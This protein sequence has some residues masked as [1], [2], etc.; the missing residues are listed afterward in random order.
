MNLRICLFTACCG[1]IGSL[2]ASADEPQT[3]RKPTFWVIPHTH[4]EG[5]VFKTREEYLE[6][7][8]PNILK[9]MRLLRE[10]P[11]YHFTLDQV[12]YVRP[13]LERY[14][15]EEADFRQ[16]IK[17]GRL[18]LAGALDVMPD[19]NMPG[20][21]T[22]VRQMQYGKGYYRQKLGVDV[23]SGWLIDTFGHHAQMPQL[24]AKGG[25]K[26]FWFVRGVPRQDFPAEFFWEGIDGTRIA[27]FYLPHSY[28]LTYGSP[29][30]APA[31]R[32]WAIKQFELLTPNVH[33]SDRVGLAGPDVAEPEDHLVARIE[34]FNRDPQAPFTM[35]M[36]VPADFEKAVTGRGDRPVWK[37]ELNPIFQGTYSS[38]IEL[39]EWMR[40]M[41]Q[42]LLT[43]EKLSAL[44]AWL[45]APADLDGIW[46]GWEPVLFNQTHDLASGV[47]T[48]HVY[49]DTIRSYEFARRR[50]EAIIDGRWDV[51]ASKIDT[52]GPGAPVVVFNTLGWTRSDIAF[53]DAGFGAGG[54]S[55]IVLTDSDAKAVPAQIVASTRYADGGLKTARL[56]FIARDVPALGYATYHIVPESSA[57]GATRDRAIATVVSS[58]DSL[59][60]LEN[61]LYRLALDP[62]NGA[63]TSLRLRNNDW[64][65]F[66]ATGNVVAREQDR[67]DLW[68]LNKGL[69][70]GS[71]VAMTKRQ[72][73]PGRGQAV[74]SDEGKGEPGT[75]L[76]GR[77][78]SELT[79]ARP[80]GS[81]RFATT[82][83]I[84]AG[85][86][87]IEITT[88]LVNQ[89]KY[90]RYQALF[91]TTI[92]QGKST[93][94][95]PFGS[96]YRPAGIEFPAQ[97][98]IDH[99]DGQRGL[100]VLNIGLPGNVVTD[101][102]MM[103]S[104]MRAHTLGAYGFGGGYEPGMSSESGLQLG[105]E[106]TMRYA[107]IAHAGDWRDAG[108][109]RA[110]WE[111]NHPLLCRNV[112]TH[113]GALPRRWGLFDIGNPNVVVSSLK[114]TAG[115]DVALRIYESS[116]RPA[117]AVAIKLRAKV[118][119]AHKSNL[120]EDPD[121]PLAADGDTVRLDLGPFEIKTIRLRL[122]DS[123][124]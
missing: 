63:I 117:P 115:G 36:A 4:W 33:G 8:L 61:E 32:A 94:E 43:A 21:E 85:L 73:V 82:V 25:F 35:R 90:V 88:R 74:F 71:R 78:F 49:G 34:E 23:T 13:F 1:L 55:G 68:E 60:T 37:G 9:A 41:E 15:A 92:K 52:Q 91:P 12:A 17:E 122:G 108:I 28:A 121:T 102:T 58:A 79:V 51:I 80:F 53:V 119:S 106:R 103:V 105:T 30:D 42:R 39:K 26:T 86:R 101:G 109:V 40:V 107:L 11:D 95:I 99:G 66:A 31:F 50:A 87:R 62:R 118:E 65:V 84:Y 104:L 89:E 83:R 38:R 3:A 70:G 48:D 57:D 7:G 47:M 93:H 69:D 56:A 72:Q 5:A 81:G 100:A 45:G 112:S 24:L 75:V 67:G 116:G 54:V 124:L 6:M 76:T 29:H 2:P 110:G 19:D 16:F 46:A 113:S 64:E 96:I 98:W 27:S 18:Q 120:I 10:Q 44:A 111:L 97:N 22:F 20:G 77:I 114:P 59:V 123:N 14:P